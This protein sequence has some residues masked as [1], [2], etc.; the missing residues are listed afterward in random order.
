MVERRTTFCEK[1]VQD[2]H[3]AQGMTEKK[4]S[5]VASKSFNMAFQD[6]MKRTDRYYRLRRE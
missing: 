3:G 2:M 1:Q 4:K 5:P 6:Q